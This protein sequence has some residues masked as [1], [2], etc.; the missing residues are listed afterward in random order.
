[1]PAGGYRERRAG[2]VCLVR[3]E[4]EWLVALW[5]LF[6]QGLIGRV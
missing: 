3:P 6:A 4:A 1:M 5:L 2:P